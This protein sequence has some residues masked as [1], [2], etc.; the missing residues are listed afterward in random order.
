MNK[1]ALWNFEMLAKLRV[2]VVGGFGGFVKSL[3]A[4]QALTSSFYLRVVV[5]RGDIGR[6]KYDLPH[7]L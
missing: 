2:D 6:R 4:R 7:H 3:T 5:E 1:K